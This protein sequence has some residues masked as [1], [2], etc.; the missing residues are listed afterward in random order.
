M[1]A[2][3][4]AELEFIP[5]SWFCFIVFVAMIGLP[6]GLKV[7]KSLLTILKDYFFSLHVR[8]HGTLLAEN[9]SS[10]ELVRH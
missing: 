6:I 3:S 2:V 10:E 4:E 1:L 7:Y 8:N 9:C 5:Y